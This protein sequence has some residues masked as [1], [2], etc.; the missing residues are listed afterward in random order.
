MPRKEAQGRAYDSCPLRPLGYAH[1]AGLVKETNVH[2]AEGLI[3]DLVE[4]AAP[5]W[6]AAWIDLGGEG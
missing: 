5:S 4:G 2:S 6:E 3:G 1:L